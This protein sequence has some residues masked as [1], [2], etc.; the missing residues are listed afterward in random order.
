MRRCRIVL[1][2]LLAAIFL[3]SGCQRDRGGYTRPNF[4]P[5]SI[6]RS[7]PLPPSRPTPQVAQD[8]PINRV[9]PEQIINGVALR[10]KVPARN[11]RYIVIHHSATES[12]SAKRIHQAHIQRGWDSLGYNFV[13]GNGTETPM[14]MIE[15]GPRW[16]YQLDGAHAGVPEYNQFGIGICLVGNFEI[17]HPSPQQLDSLARLCAFLMKTYNIPASNIIGHRDGRATACPGRNVDI[18]HIRSLAKRYL[19]QM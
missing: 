14:G 19:Q 12:S 8:R 5:P 11:W 2:G 15:I 17:S 6:E 10:P 16:T 7:G 1:C 9:T 13:I 4:S 3:L 18:N